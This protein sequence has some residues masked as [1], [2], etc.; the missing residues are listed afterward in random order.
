MRPAAWRTSW[1]SKGTSPAGGGRRP[2]AGSGAAWGMS[3]SVRQERAGRHRGC[4]QDPVAGSTA[5]RAGGMRGARCLQPGG[6]LKPRHTPP[7]LP[8]ALRTHTHAHSGTRAGGSGPACPARPPDCILSSSWC[9]SSTRLISIL[10][11]LCMLV[12]WADT[13]GWS[14]CVW[15]WWECARVVRGGGAGMACE[16]RSRPPHRQAGRQAGTCHA[17]AVA[18]AGGGRAWRR[19]T[20]GGSRGGAA[21]GQ[22]LSHLVNADP[23]SLRRLPGWQAQAEVY[24]QRAG[25]RVRGGAGV[26]GAQGRAGQRRRR[27]LRHEGASSRGACRCRVACR[28]AL[29]TLIPPLAPARHHPTRAAHLYCVLGLHENEGGHAIQHMQLCRE[30]GGAG[31]GGRCAHVCGRR[32]CR[33]A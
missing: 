30:G 8:D 31:A 18:A 9:S 5:A 28:A 26:R 21:C 2:R 13:A 23:L 27:G 33:R 16:A 29:A 14:V 7:T 10:M 4:P 1:W 11:A 25:G 6:E 17:T 19:L 24:R 15:W 22:D 3:G 20:L 32:E 12:M